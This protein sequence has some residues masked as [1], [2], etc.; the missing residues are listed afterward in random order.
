[1]KNR[2]NGLAKIFALLLL[3]SIIFSVTGCGEYNP[4]KNPAGSDNNGTG[5]SGDTGGAGD[6][7]SGDSGDTGNDSGNDSGNDGNE[8]EETGPFTVTVLLNGKTYTPASSSNPENVLKARWTDGYSTYT[9]DVGEDGVAIAPDGLDGDYTVTLLNLPNGYTY[10]PNIHKATNEKKDISIEIVKIT[11]TIGDGTELYR[12]IKLNKTGTYR[13]KISRSGQIVYY[14]FTP[15]KAGVYEI[16]SLVDIS[17]NMYNPILKVYN[18]TV[19]AK[20]EKTEVDDGGPS[21]TYTKN[22]LYKIDVDEEFLG[23]TYTFAVR[24]EG[25][26]AVYPHYVDFTLSY[27]GTYDAGLNDDSTMMVPEFIP[28]NLNYFDMQMYAV[29][30]PAHLTL[31]DFSNATYKWLKSYKDY[32]AAEKE[33]YGDSWIDAAER[34]DGKYV[35][36]EDGYKL[37][38]DD[39]YYHVYDEVK[40]AST[41]GWGPILYADITIPCQFMSSPLN[42]VEYAGNKALTVCEGT[43]NY[44]MFIEGSYELTLSHGD[45]GPYFCNNTCPCYAEYN[46]AKTAFFASLEAYTDAVESGASETAIQKCISDMKRCLSNVKSTNG[47]LCEASCTSCN[48]TCFHISEENR[49]QMGYAN[50]AVDGRCPVTEELKVFLQKLSESQ[51][52]F[53]DG[54]GWIEGMGYTAFEDSQWLFACG[55]YK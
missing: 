51:R 54:N 53:S 52:Y 2:K 10:N 30:D 16:E 37:N 22:F 49:F 32:L 5:D 1:M 43:E 50:I 27:K 23:N 39:G 14:E 4:P 33:K 38:P 47:G 6:T 20:F 17:A 36:N 35:F 46:T 48:R 13:A 40:Y 9:S 18:G 8:P 42:Q 7:D 55:Y 19:A 15:T 45:S 26:D 31:S 21:N 3:V 29:L 24:L 41:G 34:V 28:S 11:T 44:K 12:C 25:K